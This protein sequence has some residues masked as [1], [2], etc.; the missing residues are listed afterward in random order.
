MLEAF[1]VVHKRHLPTAYLVPF[2]GPSKDN[3]TENNMKS[4]NVC[5]VSAEA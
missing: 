3:I 4:G 5:R 1:T 2:A